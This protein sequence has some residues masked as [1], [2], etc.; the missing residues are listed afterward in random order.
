MSIL[1]DCRLPIRSSVKRIE[2]QICQ[3]SNFG[4]FKRLAN[5]CNVNA[6]LYLVMLSSSPFV[7]GAAEY[8]KSA[9]L[10]SEAQF[11]R[12]TI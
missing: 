1:G 5:V 4:P 10:T 6:K 9:L 3:R 11:L 12:G 2:N 7:F 8:L